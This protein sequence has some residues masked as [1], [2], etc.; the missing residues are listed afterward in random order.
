MGKVR[1]RFDEEKMTAIMNFL[2]NQSET[3]WDMELWEP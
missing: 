2:Q 1:R 3:S